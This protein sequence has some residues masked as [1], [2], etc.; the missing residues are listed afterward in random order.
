[1]QLDTE[2]TEKG[3]ICSHKAMGQ[4]ATIKRTSAG[5]FV[6][7]YTFPPS[8]RSAT[9]ISLRA[10]EYYAVA[11]AYEMQEVQTRHDL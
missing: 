9:F 11:L 5:W 2:I 8:A 10:A 3:I 7:P 6:F 1:M 4:I